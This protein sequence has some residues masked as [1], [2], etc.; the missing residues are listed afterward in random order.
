MST[1]L[2]ARFAVLASL[3]ALFFT[4][5]APARASEVG[6]L[7][8]RSP[9]TTSYFLWSSQS[10]DCWFQSAVGGGSQHY[11]AVINRAGAECGWSNIATLVWAVFALSGK[12]GPGRLVVGYL[13]A[14]PGAA[15]GIGERHPHLLVA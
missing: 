1:K 13:G 9:Q 5:A 12:V 6:L 4:A 10:Y 3:F 11:D 2:A 14:P 15:I 8:C 7:T